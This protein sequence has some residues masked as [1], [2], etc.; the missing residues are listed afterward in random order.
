[1]FVSL[2]R[3]LKSKMFDLVYIILSLF[4]CIIGVF[5]KL[6]GR[7]VYLSLK[8]PG[9]PALPIIGNALLLWNK[10]LPGKMN[11]ESKLSPNLKKCIAI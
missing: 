10:T 3:E 9:P 1:M 5:I 4:I 7:L 2:L 6:Y 11:F 8:I